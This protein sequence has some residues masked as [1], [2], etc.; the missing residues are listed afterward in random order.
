VKFKTIL[1]TLCLTI[2]SVISFP[3]HSAPIFQDSFESGNLRATNPEGFW[4][5]TPD[6]FS[7]VAQNAKTGNY[8]LRALYEAG[9]YMTE[10]RFHLNKNYTDLWIG[11]WIR[12]PDNFYHGRL[13]NKF[14]S[15]W[16]ET[17]DTRGTVTWQTRPSGSG[18]AVLVYQ[19]GGV[20]DN[21]NDGKPFISVPGDRGRWM[22]VVAHVK[23]ASSSTA[24]DGVIQF[25][26]RWNGE[27]SYTKIHEKLNANT[28]ES[29]ASAQGISHGFLM[30][31]ANDAYDQ[32]TEWFIDDFTLSET[33][34]L[35]A[36]AD[37]IIPKPPTLLAIE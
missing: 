7:V 15:V 25:F 2:L 33:S 26:R 30:G 23:S 11:Y 17:Y 10:Q 4:W 27:S 29:G 8:S 22:H 3:A 37:V 20:T 19:D 18:G 9:K 5:G 12:V 6:R 31:W 28:W 36:Q 13:N 34:L 32:N 1:T 35:T 24:K 16:P 21:E 14:L